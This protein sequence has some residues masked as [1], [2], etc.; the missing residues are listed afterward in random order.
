M[1]RNYTKFC[2]KKQGKFI[3][4]GKTAVCLSQLIIPPANANTEL[5]YPAKPN[6]KPVQT[7]RVAFCLFL[8]LGFNA[9]TPLDW[10]IHCQLY[11]RLDNAFA[12]NYQF[13]QSAEPTLLAFA[14][15]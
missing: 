15:V 7:S 11:H 1:S 10:T 13:A 14:P 6:S 12:T 2:T 4:F 8:A 5:I 3:I 9:N